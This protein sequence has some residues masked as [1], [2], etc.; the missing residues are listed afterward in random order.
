MAL[1]SQDALATFYFKIQKR[2]GKF[3]SSEP[4]WT[5]LP[6]LVIQDTTVIDIGSNIG[7]YTLRMS[8]F[9]GSKGTVIAIEPNDRIYNIA[10]SLSKTSLHDNIVHL[11]ACVANK[12]GIT[13]FLEDW[14]APKGALFSTATRSKIHTNQVK[15]LSKARPQHLRR[16]ICIQI[17]NLNLCPSLIKLDVEGGEVDALMGAQSTII[18]HKPLLIVET[19]NPLS[20]PV[21][22]KEWSVYRF[23]GSRNVIIC[24]KLDYRKHI[25][26]KFVN[27]EVQR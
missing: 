13:N 3:A 21:D 8:E 24:H 7:R 2:L 11:N 17:D 10:K 1:L 15:D 14:T 26:K 27:K 18:R 6:K 23:E 22:W 5:L 9:V 25:L 19:Y 20:I 16:K 12:G 4:E